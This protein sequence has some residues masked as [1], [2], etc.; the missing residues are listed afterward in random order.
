[1]STLVEKKT[2]GYVVKILISLLFIINTFLGFQVYKM[3]QQF[4]E[5]QQEFHPKP[6]T[7]NFLFTEHVRVVLMPIPC[8]G[9]Y[10]LE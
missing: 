8:I 9:D 10:L 2:T 4:S 6:F 1:M 5:I 3:T 7:I